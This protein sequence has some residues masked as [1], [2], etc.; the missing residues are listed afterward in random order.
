MYQPNIHS[1]AFF[2]YRY[3]LF[4]RTLSN[5]DDINLK[6]SG[7]GGYQD[8]LPLLAGKLVEQE[9]I[10]YPLVYQRVCILNTSM[11]IVDLV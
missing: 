7:V 5:D 3:M 11:Y 10:P 9:E 1:S 8:G 6:R 4:N 2:L